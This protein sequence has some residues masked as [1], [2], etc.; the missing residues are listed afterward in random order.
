MYRPSSN[1]PVNPVFK[2]IFKIENQSSRGSLYDAWSL[3]TS[4]FVK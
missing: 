1:L 2:I 3:K 4:L